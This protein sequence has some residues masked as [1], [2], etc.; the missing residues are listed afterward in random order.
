[1]G[2]SGIGGG[3]GPGS[4]YWGPIPGH[5]AQP[6]LPAPPARPLLPNNSPP[7]RGL[8]PRDIRPPVPNP[9]QCKTGPASR[10]SARSKGGQST[11]D[12]TG[13]EWRYYPGD[14][15]YHN[16]HWDYNS[17]NAPYSRWQNIPIGNMPIYK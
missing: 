7:T 1:M 16:P 13:G 10:P 11:W 9:D 4:R 2:G 17:H 6:R 12:K 5:Y 3:D 8:P 15:K 14:K